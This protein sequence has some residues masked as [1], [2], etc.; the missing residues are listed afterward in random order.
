MLR[1][2]TI[3]AIISAL[4]A[5][6]PGQPDDPPIPMPPADQLPPPPPVEEGALSEDFPEPPPVEPPLPFGEPAEEELDVPAA[7]LHHL[8][9][10]I[11]VRHLEMEDEYEMLAQRYEELEARDELTRRAGER[12]QDIQESAANLLEQ[13]DLFIAGHREVSERHDPVVTPEET[14]AISSAARQLADLH[15]DLRF[16]HEILGGVHFDEGR[17][18]MMIL[19]NRFIGLHRNL[20]GLLFRLV[21]LEDQPMPGVDPS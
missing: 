15:G 17:E 2:L 19:H 6:E 21:E 16:R 3:A 8:F 4:L 9:E 14:E 1:L 12:Y 11:E 20:E 18:D 10:H 13:Q 5:C 7:R